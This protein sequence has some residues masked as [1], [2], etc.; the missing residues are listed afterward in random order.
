MKTFK[1]VLNAM[2]I[3]V[4]CLLPVACSDK[5]PDPI[6]DRYEDL[7]A[8]GRFEVKKG[9]AGDEAVY[10][11]GKTVRFNALR[12]SERKS[13]ITKFEVFADDATTP[14]WG[15]DFV[16]G[17]RYGSFEA[18]SASKIR[19]KVYQCEDNWKLTSVEAYYADQGGAS[20][21]VM[22]YVTVDSAYRLEDKWKTNAAVM[23]EFNVIGN[24]Y[25]DRNGA[26]HY[27]DYLFD[28]K[29]VDGKTVLK[30]AIAKLKSFNPEARITL[31]VLGN[32]D[33]TSD[34]L[35]V[36]ERHNEAMGDHADTLTKNLLALLRETGATGI[37]FDYEY[38]HNL[39]SF[40]IFA[41]YLKSLDAALPEGVMLSAAVSLWC[42]RPLHLTAK[43]LSVL[44]R[45]EL[46]AYDM[47][48]DRGN[49]ATFYDTCYET[50]KELG[51]RGVD[52][53]KV[54]L[55]LPFYS[56]PV[57][58]DEFWGSY[59]NIAEQLPRFDNTIREAY[60][61]IN[62]VQKPATDQYYNGRQMIYDKTA[63][64]VDAGLRGVMI[65]HFVCDSSDPSLALTSQIAAAIEARQ[66]K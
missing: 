47:F 2:L 25:F 54:R 50:V 53:S 36:E 41:E 34:G 45:I 62:G 4:L 14:F 27:Q 46:M 6:S 28:G 40:R 7:A 63:F 33:F 39:K 48:D 31:T 60:E 30:G 19:I 58:H 1:R 10:D 12:L 52:L 29:S 13:A 61:T 51:R 20:F 66:G 64:A 44:D 57:N 55:G 38:P 24:L 37:S 21:E 26:L 17:Y 3:P 18:V 8:D 65:W 22:S 11:F 15:G 9:G 5:T 16:D 49:H 43:R 42:I 23:D 35:T 32:R 59:G 56:R